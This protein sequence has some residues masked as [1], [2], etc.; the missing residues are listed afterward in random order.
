MKKEKVV[1]TQ[2]EQRGKTKT[3]AKLRYQF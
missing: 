2:K 3:K 1:I